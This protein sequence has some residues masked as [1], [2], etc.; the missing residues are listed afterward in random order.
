MSSWP[1]YPNALSE[2]ESL[3]EQSL[4]EAEELNDF[5]RHENEDED[6]D[7]EEEEENEED[8]DIDEEEEEEDIGND[9]DNNDDIFAVSD[10]DEDSGDELS[11]RSQAT[12]RPTVATTTTT[13][14]SLLLDSPV[15][16]QSRTQRLYY[17]R[18]HREEQGERLRMASLFRANRLQRTAAVAVAAA[19]QGGQGDD[20]DDLPQ[21][22]VVSNLVHGRTLAIP[23]TET[24]SS[25]E[26][27]QAFNVVHNLFTSA[28]TETDRETAPMK[29]V[30]KDT[31]KELEKR[32]EANSAA[33]QANVVK[34][35]SVNQRLYPYPLPYCPQNMVFGEMNTY[36]HVKTLLT[37]CRVRDYELIDSQFLDLEYLQEE[38][39]LSERT[40]FSLAE[41]APM[42]FPGSAAPNTAASNVVK[43]ASGSSSIPIP[44][45]I[46]S[47]NEQYRVFM[48][49]CRYKR[50]ATVQ[51]DYIPSGLLVILNGRTFR[52][53]DPARRQSRQEVADLLRV[54]FDLTEQ[55]RTA[56]TVKHE[57]VVTFRPLVDSGLR[58]LI[59]GSP[60][61]DFYFGVYL[62]KRVDFDAWWNGF[63]RRWTAEPLSP[64]LSLELGKNS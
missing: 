39:A 61:D 7:E 34:L 18:E 19:A 46:A 62:M 2:E 50:S 5:W 29:V 52:I 6:E 21:G 32:N 25:R 20:D 49:L 45:A 60:Q 14:T 24:T 54:P 28:R 47:N 42:L 13:A 41:I 17:G 51:Q 23:E 48:R 1:P 55:L 35:V 43:T 40:N 3:L 33:P 36:Q 8:Q 12:A 27:R 64:E 9:D 4:S 53:P 37:P 63:V 10:I 56:W 57:A 58:R 22:D 30:L 15:F 16:D 26:E 11:Q 31:S 38:I 59:V 44:V